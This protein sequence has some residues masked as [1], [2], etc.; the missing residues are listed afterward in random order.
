[1]E[2]GHNGERSMFTGK[3]WYRKHFKLNKEYENKKV[4]IEFEGIR[5]AADVYINGKNWKENM[6]MD[7]FLSGMI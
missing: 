6:K 1:M 7:L 3:T 5:Q 4:F 2:G